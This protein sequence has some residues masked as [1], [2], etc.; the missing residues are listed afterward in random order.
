MVGVRKTVASGWWRVARKGRDKI[1]RRG[2]FTTEDTGSAEKRGAAEGKASE[3]DRAGENAELERLV[4]PGR[5]VHPP[6]FVSRGNKGLTGGI[7]VSRGNKGLRG[8]EQFT[9]ISSQFAVKRKAGKNSEMERMVM[10][11]MPPPPG[12]RVPFAKTVLGKSA[13]MIEVRGRRAW[14]AIVGRSEMAQKRGPPGITKT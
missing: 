8:K 1:Q 14:D 6:F 2:G 11:R 9:V 10:L 12:V 4:M 5:G 7:V 3:E 13:G